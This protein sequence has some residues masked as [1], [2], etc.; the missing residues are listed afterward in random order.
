MRWTAVNDELET[1]P[2]NHHSVFMSISIYYFIF[3]HLAPLVHPVSQPNTHFSGPLHQFY[4]IHN[5]SLYS[6]EVSELMHIHT[7]PERK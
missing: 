4:C 3:C 1:S 6:V 7:E 2:T 5:K